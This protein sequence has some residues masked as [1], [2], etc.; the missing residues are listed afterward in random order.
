MKDKKKV[1]DHRSNKDIMK[2][3]LDHIGKYKFFLLFSIVLAA[4][5]VVLTLYIPILTGQAVDCI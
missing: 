3:V 1:T 2:K 4:V 5:S